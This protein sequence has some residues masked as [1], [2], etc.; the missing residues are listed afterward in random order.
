V[1]SEEIRPPLFDRERLG[2]RRTLFYYATPVRQN[3]EQVAG[4]WSLR[5]GALVL[6]SGLF[7]PE[8]SDGRS[9]RRWA[10]SHPVDTVVGQHPRQVLK[11][12]GF[13]CDHLYGPG[14]V[15]RSNIFTAGV[16]RQV[17]LLASAWWPARARGY[18]GGW[19]LGLAG[20]GRTDE[21]SPRWRKASPHRPP[22]YVKPIGPRGAVVSFGRPEDRAFGQWDGDRHWRGR[23]IDVIATAYA[24]DGRDDDDFAHH[25]ADFSLPARE[26]PLSVDIDRD[27]AE[28]LT[29]AVGAIGELAVRIDA[30]AA[31]WCGGLGLHG[32]TSPAGVARAVLHDL[33]AR[34]RP[35]KRDR[36]AQAG[37]DA[38]W[39]EATHGGWVTAEMAGAD[40]RRMGGQ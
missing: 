3:P 29:E 14:Y 1:P 2:E 5:R 38:R 6:A 34:P 33:G 25:A 31:A 7:V 12:P 28:A 26:L 39:T 35:R 18:R 16:L 13:V 17:P 4:A 15:G 9:W 24:F 36:W 27:G 23:F 32:L 10:A 22:V 40:P 11:R 8:D 21:G 19:G 20:A 30:E 37:H